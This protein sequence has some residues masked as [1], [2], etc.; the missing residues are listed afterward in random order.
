[1][2]KYTKFTL[3]QK[4]VLSKISSSSQN[5][6]KYE[7]E[8]ILVFFY[9]L[10]SNPEATNK[11]DKKKFIQ[12]SFPSVTQHEFAAVISIF[13][14][15]MICLHAEKAILLTQNFKFP[16]IDKISKGRAINIF[17]ESVIPFIELAQKAAQQKGD[18]ACWEQRIYSAN[19]KLLLTTDCYHPEDLKRDYAIKL[20]NSIMAKHNLKY[21]K[22]QF[23]LLIEV[24]R[25]R[26]PSRLDPDLADWI[27]ELEV[28]AD[29]K[30]RQNFDAYSFLSEL[31]ARGLSALETAKIIAEKKRAGASSFSAET[32]DKYEI[33]SQLSRLGIFITQPYSTWTLLQKKYSEYR[34][35]ENTK[36]TRLSLGKLNL[37]LF[38]YLPLWLYQNKK[39]NAKYTYP[40]TPNDFLGS[41]HYKCTQPRGTHRPLSYS[42]F[43]QE[44]GYIESH[45]T[46]KSTHNF[47]SYLI[48]HCRDQKGCE[49]VNQPVGRIP[50]GKSYKTVTKNVFTGKLMKLACDFHYSLNYASE[51]FFENSKK[52]RIA[53]VNSLNNGA[54]VTDDDL[55]YTPFINMNGK[56]LAINALHPLSFSFVKHSMNHYYNPASA[57]FN[58]LMLECGFRGQ[59]LQYL[60]AG[61]YDITSH[62]L[63]K[64]STQ[65]TTLWVNTDKVSNTPFIV[66]T[67]MGN[68]SLLDEQLHWR[69]TMQHEYGV[70]AFGNKVFYNNNPKSKWGEILPLFAANSQTGAPLTDQQYTNNWNYQCLNIQTW[71]RQHDLDNTPLVGFLPL[72]TGNGK[73]F[74]WE[75]WVN[76]IDP[77]QVVVCK[78]NPNARIHVGDYCPVRFRAYATPHGARAS[79]ITE[80]S[81]FLPPDAVS[82]LTGQSVGTIIKYNK[83]HAMLHE[84]LKGVFN[85]KDVSWFLQQ[86]FDTQYSMNS[87]LEVVNESRK[88]G[89]TR[90]QIEDLG[91]YFVPSSPSHREQDGYTII[92]T[93]SELKFGANLTHI[94]PFNFKCPQ[95]VIIRFKGHKRCAQC[96]YA[97]FS[98]HNIAAIAAHKHYLAEEYELLSK[99]TDEATANPSCS[100]I[101]KSRLID[102]LET[103][104]NE[105]ISWMVLEEMLWAHI[106]LRQDKTI[107]SNRDYLI[108]GETQIVER[109]TRELLPNK[110]AGSFLARLSETCVFSNSISSDL[111]YKIDFATKLLLVNSGD[112]KQ[113]ALM[114]PKFPTPM[115]LIGLIKSQLDANQ[116]DLEKLN[117][118]L[119]MSNDEW[120]NE[121]LIYN[122]SG[123]KLL[124]SD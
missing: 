23:P 18:K 20:R 22:T 118:Y 55:G 110:S 31:L 65:L 27:S 62:R 12:K 4:K 48:D 104:A 54:M 57:R 112:I 81:I 114:P 39:N 29:K 72:S 15:L 16:A 3:T 107:N 93:D 46:E 28:A 84:R 13:R 11:E 42:E 89:L 53:I 40:N 9:D 14:A 123:F 99:K 109:L 87:V 94:C 69:N 10:M 80:I 34:Q 122:Q 1:L 30:R 67:S 7:L 103:S 116:L 100:A 95:E 96:Q 61:T 36:S 51:Y 97:V 24:L 68:L 60:D 33:T 74:E 64:E 32:I 44:L 45:Q 47:F 70:N 121:L 88:I 73:F 21:S 41:V 85:S 79:F 76:G 90:K 113:A 77:Q 6:E 43:T 75:D 2:K 117:T 120:L 91:L 5:Y 49:R 92:Q 63:S 35:H 19:A 102:E 105:L 78:G 101:E 8:A 25:E 106:Q 124:N 26:Y 119:N 37:Y 56:N 86:S 50:R 66:V 59:T 58:L 111:Q 17:C 98:I 83:G 82:L 52:I 108:N 38:L 71:L 115:R